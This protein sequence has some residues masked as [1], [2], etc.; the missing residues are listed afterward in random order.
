MNKENQKFQNEEENE[1]EE[2]ENKLFEEERNQKYSILK[3][4]ENINCFT[5]KVSLL[6]ELII[7]KPVLNKE[8]RNLFLNTYRGLI[9]SKIN[10]LRK[11]N[12]IEDQENRKGRMERVQKIEEIESMLKEEL[13]EIC[14][15]VHSLIDDYL[16][17]E[18]YDI[19]SSVFYLKMN[20]DFYR[21]EC[22]FS[23]GE[24]HSE[25]INKTTECYEKALKIAKESLK[26]ESSLSIS[27][28]L[29]YSVFLYETLNRRKDAIKFANQ[30]LDESSMLIQERNDDYHA[31][32]AQRKLLQDNISYWTKQEG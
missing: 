29:N 24:E 7:S 8:Q 21:Y 26:P 28:N 11:L 30:A 5:E 14:K 17:P 16:S 3:D 6:K 15:E 19:P 13:F 27:L 1:N 12:V 31:A 9:S 18:A 23:S 25:L 4:L 32:F 22:E 10:G 2:Q 20:G